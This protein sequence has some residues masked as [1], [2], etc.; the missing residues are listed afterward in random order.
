[1]YNKEKQGDVMD[2]IVVCDLS[3]VTLSSQFLALKTKKGEVEIDIKQLLKEPINSDKAYFN[4]T[5]IAKMY[6]VE[7]HEYL[8]SIKVKKYIEALEQKL[9]FKYGKIPVLKKTVRGRYHS[10]TWLHSK[11]IV[12]FV[13]WVDVDFAVELD[14]F[15]QDLIVYSN[16]LKIERNN[17]K[18]HFSKLT[19]AIKDI[20]IPAQKS[21][22]AKKYAYSNIAT[23]INMKV[24]GC[25]ATKYT[26]DNG[27]VIEEGKSIRDYLPKH[28]VKEIDSL[29]EDV[30]GYIKFANIT[31]YEILKEERLF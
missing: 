4:A 11:L 24:L 25:P 3:Q 19:D 30:W 7:M 15:I 12:D 1:M 14:L 9:S 6:G 13:R 20:W 21:E 26:K 17:A 27:I 29:E 22:N 5:H 28:K 2:S 18:I 10:G 31:N 8:R 16:E 23:L